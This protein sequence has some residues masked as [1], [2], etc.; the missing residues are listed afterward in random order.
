MFECAIFIF[1]IN[2][3]PIKELKSYAIINFLKQFIFNLILENAV[4]IQYSL[5][6][7]R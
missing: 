6:S 3:H 5:F 7:F 1:F 4:D 2:V